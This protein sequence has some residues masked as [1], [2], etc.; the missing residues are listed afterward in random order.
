[1]S[2]WKPKPGDIAAVD[3]WR[4]EGQIAFRVARL[5][6]GAPWCVLDGV[7]SR[8]LDDDE[9][10]NCRQVVVIDLPNGALAGWPTLI[11]ALRRAAVTTGL[12]MVFGGLIE[13]IE[14]QTNPKPPKPAEPMGLGAVVEYR[15]R[16]DSVA[17][18]VRNG[19]SGPGGTD[20]LDANGVWRTWPGLDVARILSDGY[21]EAE[22]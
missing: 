17:L 8:G 9:V 4:G 13:Q 19:T 22:S 11:E 3:S 7:D 6:N 20:W 21:A 12:D 14:A 10:T 15:I 18:A 5:P 16:T 1:M 2:D